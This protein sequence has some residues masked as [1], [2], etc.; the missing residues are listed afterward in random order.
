MSTITL[1]VSPAQLQEMQAA[2]QKVLNPKTPPYALFAA[3]NQGTTITAYRSG[4]VVFQGNHAQAEA[5]KWDKA[6]VPKTAQA[7]ANAKSRSLPANFA[8]LAV[9]GSDEVGNGSYFGPLV[10]CSAYVAPEQ[11]ALLKE[12]GVKDSK[13][14]TDPQIREIAAMLKVTIP[15]KKL[16]LTP[17]K[18]NEIQPTYNAVRMKVALHNQ[19]IFLLLQ[20]L[21]PTEP[22]AILID[23]F[24]PKANYQKYVAQEKNQVTAPIYFETKGEQYH[25]AVAAASILARASFLDELER[26]SKVCG[27]TLPSGA[28]VK[29]DQIAAKILR[30]GGEPALTE[31]AKLHF[32]NTEKAKKIAFR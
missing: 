13:L 5:Q 6:A 17:K 22:D 10:V 31:V 14:L 2:Y 18:Y 27:F 24:T 15:Y 4:K 19:A 30:H 16:I 7:K 29:S 12:Y 32:A 20:D 1:A 25:L 3:K 23:Q 21:A 9:L 8:Q 28:G 11:F 26:L